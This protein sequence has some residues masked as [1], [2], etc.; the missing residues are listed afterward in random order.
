MGWDAAPL[1]GRRFPAA[2]FQL[3]CVGEGREHVD[4]VR[5]AGGPAIS[6]AARLG[7]DSHFK[8]DTE[9][10]GEGFDRCSVAE[11]FSRRCVE[12]PDDVIDVGIG[13]IREAGLARKIAPETAVG[14]LKSATLPGA[15]RVAEVGVQADRLVAA[16][17]RANSPPLSWVMVRRAVAGSPASS[18]AIAL[19]ARSA[20]LP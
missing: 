12:V 5:P 13:V 4:V 15:M 19:A 14:V 3:A 17:C 2:L 8:C 20:S 1:R 9:V 11:A 16:S 7:L 18:A 6:K 10:G